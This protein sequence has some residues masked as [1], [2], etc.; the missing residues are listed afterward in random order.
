MFKAHAREG[1][2]F[3]S[4]RGR[5][6]IHAC[7]SMRGKRVGARATQKAAFGERERREEQKAGAVPLIEIAALSANSGEGWC[8]A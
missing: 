3:E 2:R 4:E 7:V 8:A 5:E 1:G 6:S